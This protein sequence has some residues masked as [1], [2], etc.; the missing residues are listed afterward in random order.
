MIWNSEGVR[1]LEGEALESILRQGFDTERREAGASAIA[2]KHVLQ[3][4]EFSCRTLAVA[5]TQNLPGA[6]RRIN[7]C[8]ET[9]FIQREVAAP[10]LRGA[11]FT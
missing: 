8:L 4:I 9:A 11:A 10:P 7:D 5:E 2:P 6:E 3:A 1:A